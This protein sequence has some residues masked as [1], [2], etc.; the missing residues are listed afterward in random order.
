MTE[1]LYKWQGF[2]EQS[3]LIL[4][5]QNAQ[6]FNA[7][8]L[9]LKHHRNF[10]KSQNSYT[11]YEIDSVEEDFGEL[12]RVWNERTLLGSFYE[13]AQGQWRANPYYQDGQLIGLEKDLSRT[14]KSIS[15]AIAYI[16][17]THERQSLVIAA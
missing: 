13:N 17:G 5:G 16:Q 14:F 8:S 4:D 3:C 10:Q 2:G 12:F 9:E 11:Q 6:E 7:L 1:K 15:E